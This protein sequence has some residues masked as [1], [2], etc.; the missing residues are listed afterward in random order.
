MKNSLN[1]FCSV[2]LFIF[3]IGTSNA[4]NMTK[5]EKKAKQATELKNLIDSKNYI[6]K[7]T[8]ANPLNGSQMQLTSSYDLK[9]TNDSL[10]AYLPYFGQAYLA[11]IN[12]TE[13]GIKF[14]ATKFDYTAIQKKNGNFEVY[15]EPKNLNPRAPSDVAKMYLTVSSG[16]YST[17]QVICI[18]RQSISFSGRV[19]EITPK[20]S[21]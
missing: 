1:I 14:T 15:F 2:L 16:G 4:Q 18:N 9:L 13:G 8:L 11:P 19:E 6:F 10:I 21:K 5:A 3:C 20:A 7:A 17:L 12:A